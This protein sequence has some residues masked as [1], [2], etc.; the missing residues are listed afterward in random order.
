MA[1]SARRVVPARIV[2][3]GP[4]AGVAFALQRGKRELGVRAMSTGADL[5]FDFTL[6]VDFASNGSPRFS[7]QFVQGPA[8]GKFV[9]INSGTLAGQ[10]ESPWTRRAKVGL[11]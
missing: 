3:V 7:G 2:V 11:K 5:Q 6:E 4:P 9:Y 8:A 1:R 10:A